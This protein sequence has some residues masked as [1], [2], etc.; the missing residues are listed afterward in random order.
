MPTFREQM[1]PML[2]FP[3]SFVSCLCTWSLAHDMSCKANIEGYPA[4]D[5]VIDVVRP[6]PARATQGL[7][8]CW[9]SA[10]K[11]Q[12]ILHMP[13]T[14]AP[15]THWLDSLPHRCDVHERIRA[16]HAATFEVT[17]HEGAFRCKDILHSR[18]LANLNVAVIS[19]GHTQAASKQIVAYI[20][21]G[22]FMS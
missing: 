8:N 1:P 6:C 10:T 15:S 5:M 4:L 21:R 7:T 9:A 20:A 13:K 12:Q 22:I 19:T 18:V 16:S 2:K 14:V 17:C 3:G 11:R